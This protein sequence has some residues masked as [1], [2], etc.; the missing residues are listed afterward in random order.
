MTHTYHLCSNGFIFFL[1]AFRLL[2]LSA[3]MYFHLCWFWW[4]GGGGSPGK[5]RGLGHSRGSLGRGKNTESYFSISF[6]HIDNAFYLALHLLDF[7]K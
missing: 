6:E 3:S 5:M 7:S 2:Y 4:K 1:L